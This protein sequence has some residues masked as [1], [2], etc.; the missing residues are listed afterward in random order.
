MTE[1]SDHEVKSHSAN[2]VE[3]LQ[4][5]LFVQCSYFNLAIS[6]VSY[7]ICFKQKLA[8]VITIVAEWINTYG[9]YHWRIFEVAIE[10]LFQSDLNPR[11]QNSVQRL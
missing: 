5:H 6:S 7:Q 8:Q 9:I 1:I 2:F 3:L 4:Y 10:S 11:P